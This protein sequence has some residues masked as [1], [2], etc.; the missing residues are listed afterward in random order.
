MHFTSTHWAPKQINVFRQHWLILTKDLS[1]Q[2]K[3]KNNTTFNAILYVL[4]KKKKRIAAVNRLQMDPHL[5]LTPHTH[6][7]REKCVGE[8]GEMTAERRS[9]SEERI[10]FR[11]NKCHRSDSERCR[12]KGWESER[13]RERDGERNDHP[14]VGNDSPPCDTHT[15][16]AEL[17]QEV[18]YL[19]WPLTWQWR[20]SS[21]LHFSDN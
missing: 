20:R 17:F 6:T 7:Q 19:S 18:L 10:Q 5:S 2:K 16:A 11:G 15:L 13:G 12:L 1:L 9:G 4:E 3:K 8:Q 14:L 21:V